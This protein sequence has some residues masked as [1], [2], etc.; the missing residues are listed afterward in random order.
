MLL[1]CLSFRS[2]RVRYIPC[3][4]SHQLS[5][6]EIATP[7]RRYENSLQIG[8]RPRRPLPMVKP[9]RRSNP[10]KHHLTL[11]ELRRSKLAVLD[12]L[13]S[14][15]SRRSYKHAIDEFI[16]WYCSRTRLALN[17][18]VVLRYQLHLENISTRTFNNQ[19]PIGCDSLNCVRTTD[20]G[21]LSPELVAGIRRVKGMKRWD[22]PWAIGS[23]LSRVVSSW[24]FPGGN[25]SRKE[26]PSNACSPT[27]VRAEA[28]GIGD[29]GITSD[30]TAGSHWVIVDL[31]GKARHT[32]RANTI[33]GQ[34]GSG[35]L[36]LSGWHS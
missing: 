8:R 31:V 28:V 5:R 35:R 6:N 9:T 15:Q 34:S 24:H 36:D 12:G 32:N 3:R 10:S 29:S 18:A 1:K 33:V 19:R 26:G 20:T 22:D 23:R 16:C 17:Q 13:G 30:S 25:A 27:R 7:C 21:L 4:S 14:L 11:P 2:R